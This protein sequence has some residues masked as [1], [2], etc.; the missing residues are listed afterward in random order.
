MTQT[1]SYSYDAIRPDQLRLVRF[2]QRGNRTYAVLE[3]FPVHELP[4]YHALSYTWA[5]EKTGLATS[6]SIQIEQ[7]HLPV[8]DTLQPF[9]EALASKS[10]LSEARWWIDSICLDQSNLEE[11][12]EQVQLMQRIYHQADEVII[13]LGEES[14][15]SNLAIDFIELHDEIMRSKT[16]REEFRTMLLKEKYHAHWTALTNFISRKW[17]S[18]IWTIQEFVI[19]TSASFWCGMRSVGRTAVCHSISVADRCT[20]VSIKQT[21]AF[22]HA[23]NR[24][25]AFNLY[26]AAQEDGIKSSRTVLALTAYF[27][28][29]DVTDDRDR[30]YG[31]RAL[32]TDGDLL[33]VTYSISSQELFLR[34]AQDFIKHHKSLDIICFASLYSAPSSSTQPSWVPHWQRMNESLVLPLMVSQS[35][36][37][38]VGNLR[39]PTHIPYD[40]S[41]QYSASNGRA[42]EFQFQHSA[43]LARGV[44]VDVIDGIAGSRNAAIVQSTQD[45]KHD[46]PYSPLEVLTS[47]CRSLVLDR[48]DRFLRYAMPTV[49]FVR[50]FACLLRPLITE[51]SASSTP[52][53]L[54]DWFKWTQPLRINGCSLE[55]ILR[56][57]RQ[58]DIDYPGYVPNQDEYFYDSFFG[59]FFDTVVRMSLRLMISCDGRFGMVPEKAM[60]GDK[61]CVLFGCNVPVLLR[62]SGH[63]D[64]F[65]FIGECFLTECMNGL[66]LDQD[67]CLER[68]FRIL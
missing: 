22:R 58:A 36:N 64:D 5:S 66:V 35:S 11:R 34:F 14:V 23:F 6:W 25:R 4:P 49:E 38:H 18:R 32:S 29:M 54:H 45:S 50:D 2:S 27:C 9:V 59:R 68:T 43:L 47:V 52:K 8:L 53:E 46:L 19:P 62:K 51:E 21:A 10:L 63:E 15:D 3:T 17:W 30:L 31:L 12:A 1:T 13:W 55:S 7:A 60:K 40:P 33:K 28:C 56:D 37:S 39:S 44:I 26:V 67:N 65:T 41:I 48:K 20:T 42:A 16:S 61:I 57:S 24:R